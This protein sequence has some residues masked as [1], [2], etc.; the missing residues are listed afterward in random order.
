MIIDY[1]YYSSHGG[2]KIPQNEFDKYSTIA[3]N[4]II[5][6][7]MNRD[8]T[9]YTSV[10]KNTCMLIVDLVYDRETLKTFER[11]K[12]V[13]VS[14]SIASEKVGDYSITYSNY[15]TG[16]ISN[17]LISYDNEID[18]IIRDNLFWTGL[19]N[20]AIGVIR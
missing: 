13:G 1:S 16:D 7:I 5:N 20:K 8:Y 15:G 18:N 10:V 3:S 4:I 6:E 11:S 19:L 17:V 2:N 14:T 9:A 12:A